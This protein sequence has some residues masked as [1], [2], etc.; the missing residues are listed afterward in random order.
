MQDENLLLRAPRISHRTLNVNIES[1][2]TGNF[3]FE[4][5]DDDFNMVDSDEDD[6]FSFSTLM[7]NRPEVSSRLNVFTESWV[8][9]IEAKQNCKTIRQQSFLIYEALMDLN[10]GCSYKSIR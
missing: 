8:S 3:V 5:S 4:S 9:K 7:V 6:E 2:R 10:N 1:M